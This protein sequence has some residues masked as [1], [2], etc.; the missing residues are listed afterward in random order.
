ME[1]KYSVLTASVYYLSRKL[2]DC[3]SDIE[4]ERERRDG[5][6]KDWRVLKHLA[7]G[8]HRKRRLINISDKG[9]DVE[10]QRRKRK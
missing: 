5:F 2:L 4:R 8:H 6:I 1:K 7:S 10:G 9:T 3:G